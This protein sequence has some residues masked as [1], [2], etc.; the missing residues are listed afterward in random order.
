MT[1]EPAPSGELRRIGPQRD[2]LGEC[3]LWDERTECLW[4]VDIRRPAIRRLDPATGRI[5]T[6]TMP[7]LVGSI[8]LTEE[9]RLLVALPQFLALFD[10]RT[11]GLEAF[12]RV[13]GRMPGHRFNDGRCDRQGRFWVGSMHN[14]TRAPEGVLYRL[15]GPGGLEPVQ[16]GIS[17]P[18]SLAFS[19]D[20]HTMYFADSLKYSLY[21]Y[22]YDPATGHMGAQ[23][24]FATTEPPGFP[25][26]SAVDAEGFLWNAQFDA[27][28]LVR[29]APDGRIDRVVELPVQRPTCCAFGGPDLATLY[30]TTCSQKMSAAELEAQ[31]LAGALLAF[32]PGV[33]GLPEPR[34]ST[35]HAFDARAAQA[36]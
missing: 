7:D 24:V 25:D 3:P 18:N 10:S 1:H 36:A 5:D 16:G 9:G 34:F 14:L 35:Q 12:A 4:W 13:P 28:R 6:W 21:A 22:D 31:P 26:G 23:R 8:A 17:I 32:E 29:Y 27:G 2:I 19:P 33:R 30:V 11:G 15:E 20:G